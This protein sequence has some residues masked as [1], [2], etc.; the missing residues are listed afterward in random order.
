MRKIFREVPIEPSDWLKIFFEPS[1]RSHFVTVRAGA[2]Q[3]R[4]VVLLEGEGLGVGVNP[5]NVRVPPP[6]QIIIHIGQKCLMDC[7]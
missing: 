6:M 7:R 1:R 3:Q 2:C 4:L 5:V